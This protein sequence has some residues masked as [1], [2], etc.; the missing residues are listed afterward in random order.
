MGKR[1]TILRG[2]LPAA[3]IDEAG[4]RDMATSARRLLMERVGLSAEQIQVAAWYVF[5]GFDQDEIANL[6][7]D[8]S[9]KPISRVAVTNRI[10][11]IDRKLQAAG[12]PKLAD[13]RLK[14]PYY[15]AGTGGAEA[16]PPEH[17]CDTFTGAAAHGYADLKGFH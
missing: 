16:V 17:V 12:L 14:H 15:A 8:R 1:S 5:D 11:K 9:G 3:P 13:L 10:K 6:L 2:E 4:R 7:P